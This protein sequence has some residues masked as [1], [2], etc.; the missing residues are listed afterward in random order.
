MSPK[1]L[2]TASNYSHIR[3][4]H[5][6]YLE[7]FRSLGWTIHV[8]CCGITGDFPEADCFFELPFK[9]KLS[10][11]SNLKAMRILR[12]VLKRNHY[13]LIC[14]HTSLAA[15]FTRLT[16]GILKLS[17]PVVNVVHGYLYNEKQS[18]I[19]DKILLLAE[20]LL[21]KRTDLLLT[22]NQE[23][24]QS[25]A[26]HRLCR[27]IVKIPGMGL[28]FSYQDKVSF[29]EA[30]RLRATIQQDKKDYFLL[31]AAEFS[32]RKNQ[33]MLLRA[34]PKLPSRI[35]LILPG[36][37]A[38]LEDC[39]E[40]AKEL[41]IADRV[42][43]PGQ[44]TNMPVW[45]AA[46]DAYVSASHSEGMSFSV[47]EAMY[48][49]LPVVL[50]QV[51]GH[52]DLIVEG[53]NGLL[54]PCDDIDGFIKQMMRLIDDTALAD[55]L[56]KAAKSTASAYALEQV[57]PKVMEQYLSAVCETIPAARKIDHGTSPVRR[58]Q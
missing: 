54:Y 16:V 42:I 3:F 15:F 43:L 28:N 4:F 45:Y 44:V 51:K 22:M 21:S 10:L 52:T 47:L 7:A 57:L 40:M 32:P 36:E 29:V 33:A 25:A 13:D 31:Y 55:R 19:R 56:G 18:G 1:V 58:K 24:Y 49:G 30:K 48:A 34:L 14:T 23:D 2:F 27:C 9:K 41:G 38:L 39:R 17:T 11:V 20:K 6:P 46:C 37:G 5:L 26:K 8:G 12:Q 53:Q 50:S 35:R